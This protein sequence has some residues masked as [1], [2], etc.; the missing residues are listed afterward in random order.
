MRLRYAFVL[1]LVMASA[2]FFYYA[3]SL[4]PT[5]E[6][7]GIL[8]AVT[9]VTQAD[10]VKHVGGDGV[11]VV[12]MVP[13][14]ADPHAYEPT[15]SQLE[16]V[17]RA[18]IYFM[19]GSGMGFEM[20]WMEKLKDLN[21][22]VL[23]VNGSEGISIVNG[24]PH[25]WLSPKNAKLMVLNFYKGLIK[26]DPTHKEE[27]KANMESYLKELDSLDSYI[28]AELSGYKDRTFL[29]YHPAFGYFSRDY[30][31]TQIS[32]ESKGKAPS[33]ALMEECVRLAREHHLSYVY[34][35]PQFSTSEAKVVAREIGGEVR[36]LNPM[37]E[38]YV[39]GMK[40]VVDAFEIE[41]E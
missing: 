20:A 29:V 14:D 24:D 35:E 36:L 5:N 18:K 7:K 17:S 27:Y 10:F 41:F 31:L 28:R 15:P 2:V 40:E 21:P 16:K 38:D 12:V 37:P 3:Y 25:V 19:I 13:P 30:N 6:G 11:E 8:V 4:P 23:V 9:M 39:S 34:I 22:N 26:V 32:I 1:A 33:P